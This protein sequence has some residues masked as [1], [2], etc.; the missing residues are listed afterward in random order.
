MAKIHE[1][2][3]HRGQKRGRRRE[4]TGSPLHRHA[5]GRV[6]RRP[7]RRGGLDG[8]DGSQPGCRDSDPDFYRGVG[9]VAMGGPHPPPNRGGALPRAV[10]LPGEGVLRAHPPAKRGEATVVDGPPD[11]P[12][13][14]RREGGGHLGLRR[15]GAGPPVG[16]GGLHRPLPPL[17]AAELA[18][19]G[20]FSLWRAGGRAPAAAG[21][22]RTVQRDR[23]PGVR[24]AGRGSSFI[25][26]DKKWGPISALCRKNRFDIGGAVN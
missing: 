19:G 12:F 13:E 17:G 18:G 16:G 14:R 24:A 3:A 20:A 5:L 25:G 7:G 4:Q 26:D 11:R 15:S 6:Y 8:G 9:A 10:A 1:T 21:V 22:G 2:G 23:R